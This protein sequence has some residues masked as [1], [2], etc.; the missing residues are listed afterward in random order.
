MFEHLKDIKHLFIYIFG[1]CCD[2]KVYVYEKSVRIYNRHFLRN[3]SLL[4]IVHFWA[5]ESAKRC[6][7]NC[8]EAQRTAIYQQQQQLCR[9]FMKLRKVINPKCSESI[10]IAS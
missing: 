1:K 9:T 4:R 7:Y 5:R 6:I 3:N 10:S 8:T 2:I